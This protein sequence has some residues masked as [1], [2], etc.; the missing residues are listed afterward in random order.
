VHCCPGRAFHF[1]REWPCEGRGGA[2]RKGLHA[3]RRAVRARRRL[4]P[5]KR[6]HTRGTVF[7]RKHHAM[8]E[9][10][11]IAVHRLLNP[12]IHLVG[13][14]GG[15]R[16]RERRRSRR[17]GL[18]H[19]VGGVAHL[20][21]EGIRGAPRRQ[22]RRRKLHRNGAASERQTGKRRRG[23]NHDLIA[24]VCARDGKSESCKGSRRKPQY[25]R[26]VNLYGLPAVAAR[27]PEA[28]QNG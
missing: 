26:R 9:D 23:R 8:S 20:P 18:E 16:K 21:L 14:G 17:V 19:G 25:A 13:A 27:A 6:D 22:K 5:G 2:R 28:C 15:K 12:H 11:I 10:G 3:G 1:P 7:E 4:R 24:A